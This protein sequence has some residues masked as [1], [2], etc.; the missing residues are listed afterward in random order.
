MKNFIRFLPP[1]RQSLDIVSR[2][3]HGSLYE[4][5]QN[6]TLK[7]SGHAIHHKRRLRTVVSSAH[8]DLFIIKRFNCD[9]TRIEGR[10]SGSGNTDFG[11]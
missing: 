11:G 8:L 3:S 2:Y 4:L 10:G 5:V 6:I 1:L 9:E 7:G